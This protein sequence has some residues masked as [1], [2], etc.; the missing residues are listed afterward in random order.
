MKTNLMP[1]WLRMTSQ[2]VL[3]LPMVG[4]IT[5]ALGSDY[6]KQYIADVLINIIEQYGIGLIDLGVRGLLGV[7]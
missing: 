2:L 3:A 1:Q 6:F 5:Q 4:F 7:A